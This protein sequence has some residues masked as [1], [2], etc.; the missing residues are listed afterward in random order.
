MI[1]SFPL[2]R[3][4]NQAL[5]RTISETKDFLQTASKDHEKVKE[6]AQ[7]LA[8]SIDH[9][10]EQK[11]GIMKGIHKRVEN[12][13]RDAVSRI[14]EYFLSEEV[15][16][17][18]TSWTEENA[19]KESSDWSKTQENIQQAL[20]RRFQEI[21]Q[22]WFEDSMLSAGV[23]NILQEVLKVYFP[24]GEVQLKN[25][26]DDPDGIDLP[27][28]SQVNFGGF[29]SVGGFCSVTGVS[30]VLRNVPSWGVRLAVPAVGLM[31]CLSVEALL[32]LRRKWNL[33]EYQAG[34]AVFMSKQAE[35]YFAYMTKPNNLS[36]YINLHLNS[37]KKSIFEIG[38]VLTELMAAAKKKLQQKENKHL[39]SLEQVKDAY[40]KIIAESCR[41]HSELLAVTELCSIG[42]E[43]LDWR[44]DKASRLGRG[45]FGD[46]Y[47]GK[48]Q[49]DEGIKNVALKVCKKELAAE[50][51][52]EILKEI[53]TL[54]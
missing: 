38:P 37:S 21:L 23:Q 32:F 35:E 50:N 44:E 48:I 46:V 41:G 45:T 19:P 53:E 9:F 52:H 12:Y 5:F 39:H 54:R 7:R 20:S 28:Y 15:K 34:K 22:H 16:A 27:S 3:K 42:E 1:T 18:F 51:A 49:K 30:I 31:F 24:N 2:F 13:E 47:Q 14:R 11:E 8:K 33:Q 4:L 17:R 29:S 25:S 40:A 10:E 26:A 6:D 36:K 43:G